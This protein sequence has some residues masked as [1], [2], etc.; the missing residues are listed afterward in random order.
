MTRAAA[1]SPTLDYAGPPVPGRYEF[2]LEN[3][4]AR[5]LR[6]RFLWFCGTLIVLTLVTVP[7]PVYHVFTTSGRDFAVG[8]LNAGSSLVTLVALGWAF[9]YVRRQQRRE[10]RVYALAFWIVVGLGLFSLLTGRI[11]AQVSFADSFAQG[12]EAGREI[13]RGAAAAR[14]EEEARRPARRAIVAAEAALEAAEEA[15]DDDS[16]EAAARATSAA[17]AARAAAD[18]A[19]AAGRIPWPDR[20]VQDAAEAS[21]DAAVA[22]T[23]GLAAP[24]P[25]ELPLDPGDGGRF[26]AQFGNA[27]VVSGDAGPNA[28]PQV[29]AAVKQGASLLMIWWSVFVTHLIACL[30]LPWTV[31]EAWRPAYWLLGG[32]AAIVALDTLVGYG[33]GWYLLG[34]AIFLP[35]APL[36]GLGWC[37][38]RHSAFRSRFRS[39]F[40]SGEFRRLNKDLDG[41]RRIHEGCLP[42]PVDR[43]PLRIGYAYEPMSQIGGDLVFVHPRPEDVP[44]APRRTVVLLDVTGHGIA[45]ALTVNRLVGELERLFA[46]RPDIPPGEVLSMVNRYVYLTLAHHSVYVTGL[47]IGVGCDPDADPWCD[48]HEV[49]FTNAGHPTAFVRRAGGS[50]EPLESDC[51]MLG[52][53]PPDLFEPEPRTLAL[54]PGDALVAYT[55]GAAEAADEEGRM[56]GIAGVRRLVEQVAREAPAHAWPEAIIRRVAAH[57]NAPPGDD[58][59]VVALHRPDASARDDAR[60]SQ[61]AAEPQLA[62]V[63]A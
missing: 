38:W 5:M 49:T 63:A 33:S 48:P 31:R 53:L 43:G 20:P 23:P 39:H 51:T 25:P 30:F 41:A 9:A 32:A 37:W 44:D 6:R 8:L 2:E 3:E 55:D 15:I 26:E 60:P 1:K 40:E 50:V 46:E 24:I 35:V 10:R 18:A 16:P 62:G 34:G 58:T 12:F 22:A 7:F 14:R 61:P 59:L 47:A 29:V 36:P 45:A 54:D 27:G 28:T 17:E 19:D 52:V 4:R 56:I 13:G 57:R 42:G 11:V 21:Q